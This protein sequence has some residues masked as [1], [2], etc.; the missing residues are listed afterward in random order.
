G[1]GETTVT[2]TALDPAGNE[3][4]CTTTVTVVDDVPL[5]L[6]CEE[7]LTQDAPEDACGWDGTLT[8]TATDNCAIDIAVVDETNQY[9][10]GTHTV[11]F[12]A[13][14]ESG[15]EAT[16]VTTLTVI[17]VT[18]PTAL[19][20]ELTGAVP[21]VI[22][23]TGD[24]ACGVTLSISGLACS[25]DVDGTTTE[26]AAEDCPATVSGAQ[27]AI[28]E[29]LSE[30][31]L[32]LAYTV[33]AVDP[34]GN[35]TVVEC[36]M[37][38]NPDADGDGV[39]DSDDNCISVPNKTQVDGDEDGVGDAC[40]VCA[41]VADA[42]QADTDEDGVGDAC[43]LCVDTTD[44]AQG[45]ADED[46]VGD[47]CDI[48]PAVADADQTD[49][50]ENGVGDLCQDTDEDGVLDAETSV[51][52][53]DNCV[54]IVNAEQL[55]WDEDG[56]GNACDAEDTSLA[57]AGSGGCASSGGAPSGFWMLLMFALVAAWTRRRRMGLP[58]IV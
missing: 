19:C 42:D 27:I 1:V 39:I 23:A 30:G 15:N 47:A 20:G 7:T 21:A 17:D 26:I 52:P 49:V 33:T 18:D 2:F 57:A 34:S 38:F 45:D 11:T 36:D 44:A 56:I 51:G 55:D 50:D 37:V 48:C 58:H 22:L 25:R 32:L 9:S 14:D 4:S 53:A 5:T 31:D 10:V 8:A 13:A 54:D 29:R 41:A 28:D 46:G 24:D 12:D 43:D 3:A 6:T 40:D 35:E 16:C